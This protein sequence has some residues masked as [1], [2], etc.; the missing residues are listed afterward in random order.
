[1]SQRKVIT[2]PTLKVAILPGPALSE[3]RIQQRRNRGIYILV[4][5]VGLV[6][7]M[8]TTAKH[9]QLL[10]LSKMKLEDILTTLEDGEFED[11]ELCYN[12]ISGLITKLEVSM[13]ETTQDML[14]SEQSLDQ[15]KDWSTA[16][17]EDIKL[18]REART[19]AKKSLSE[20]LEREEEE[21][22]Q[23]KV[24]NQ[25]K[26]NEENM[27]TRMLEMKDREEATLRQ[28]QLEEEWLRK[29]LA[30]E[31][32]AKEN[33]VGPSAS[34]ISQAVKLQRYTIT[35]FFGDYKDW[36]RF[37]NQFEVEV[38]GAKISEISKFNYLLEL[39]KD[40][41]REDILGLPHTVEGYEEAKRILKSTYGK[42]FKVHKA[43]IKELESLHSIMNIHQLNSVHEFYNKLARI[44]R[45]L[46]TMKKLQT[47]QSAV[48]TL[49]D[50]LGPVREILVQ[51]DDNWEKWTLEDL[52]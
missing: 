1:M 43:L 25:Q 5:L 35:P 20:G 31:K 17:K 27:K 38:D 7:N 44:V 50:K 14:E 41:P 24:E 6:F 10:Q 36:I 33:M 22:L 29:K 4:V 37:W 19:R 9:S 51:T 42:D 13:D 39:V 8:T 15:I 45:T 2:F 26:L 52:V 40:K 28:Q 18:F 32:E 47:A 48:Y 11:I 23:R 49:M 34:S 16:Q 46:A 12:R 3:T 21:K 30:I